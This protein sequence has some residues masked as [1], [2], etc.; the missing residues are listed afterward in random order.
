MTVKTFAQVD[1]DGNVACVCQCEDHDREEFTD[2]SGRLKF[3]E[4][5]EG[6]DMVSMIEAYKWRNDEWVFVGLRPS[7]NHYW[8]GEWKFHLE[9]AKAAKWDE[10]K[11]ARE[12][13]ELGGFTWNGYRFDSNFISQ[14]RIQGMVTLALRTPDLGVDWTLADNTTIDLTASELIELGMEM[15]QFITT[16]HSKSRILRR[17]INAATTQAELDAITWV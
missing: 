16:V 2:Q 1:Q 12:A 13:E 11:R 14:S 3:I 10:I 4:P 7:P 8:D 17:Q 6:V 15:A 5:P 9:A